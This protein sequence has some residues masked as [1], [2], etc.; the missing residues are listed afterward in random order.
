ME[1]S[2]YVNKYKQARYS[3]FRW[4]YELDVVYKVM[5][6]LSFA[7]VTGVLAQVRIYLPW[8]PV[9]ITGQTFAVLFSA[10]ML[11]KWWGGIS[12]S[13]YVGIGLAGIPWFAPKTGM[14]IFSNGG[15]SVLFGPTGG[16][17]IGFI[18]AAFFLGYF[19]D[20]Y[21]RSRNFLSMFSLMLF[22]N[23]IIIFGLGLLQLYSWQSATGSYQ[24][25]WQLLMIGLIPFIIGDSIKLAGAAALTKMITPKTA[26]NGEVDVEKSRSWRIP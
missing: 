18:I 21:I 9:P 7:C 8:S 3:F 15:I 4:R 26:F 11:G 13:I 22:A 5:L 2:L 19:M 17:L 1:I 23:F 10:V 12:Q 24:G 14:P 16:Y 20:R 25:L 6:A